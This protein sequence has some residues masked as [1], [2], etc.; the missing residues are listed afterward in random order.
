MTYDLFDSSD[1]QPQTQ[2]L[3]AGTFLLR[4]FASFVSAELLEALDTVF[5][6]APLR[7]METPGGKP[8]SVTISCCGEWGWVSD[9]SGY[10]YTRTDPETLQPWPSLPAVFMQVAQAAAHEAGYSGFLPDA[11][12]INHYAPGAKMS[13]HQDKDERDFSA[14]IVSISLGLPAIF[15][16]GGMQRS[17][18]TQRL[19]LYHGDV[20][21]WGREDRLRF[22]GVMPLEHGKHELLGN[23]RM[24]LTFRKAM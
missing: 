3:S 11:C 19:P 18:K 15:L 24:N 8:M 1:E 23:C 12:L 5:V 20:L 21:V 17:D 7:K 22:H 10:C 14:P 16:L 9:R 2:Q 4:H 13:L 6:Q